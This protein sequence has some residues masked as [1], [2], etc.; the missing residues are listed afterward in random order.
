LKKLFYMENKCIEPNKD[1]DCACAIMWPDDELAS[2]CRCVCHTRIEEDAWITQKAAE[3]D[4]AFIAAGHI[5]FSAMFAQMKSRCSQVQLPLKRSSEPWWFMLV[6]AAI[7]FGI[8]I[9][10]LLLALGVIYFAARPH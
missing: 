9:G 4:G 2:H 3:E 6:A 10:F 8:T 5:G 1:Y 7:S